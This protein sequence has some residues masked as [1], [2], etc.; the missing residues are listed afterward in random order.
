MFV[1]MSLTLAT[2]FAMAARRSASASVDQLWAEALWASLPAVGASTDEAAKKFLAAIA[3]T[4]RKAPIL[5]SFGDQ[6]SGALHWKEEFDLVLARIRFDGFDERLLASLDAR[7]RTPT[8]IRCYVAAVADDPNYLP[9]WYRLAVHAEG[10][11]Q[12]RAIAELQR[13]DPQNA[14]GWYLQALRESKAGHPAESLAA[15]EAGNSLPECRWYPASFPER[16]TL[17]VPDT[18]DAREAGIAG[19]RID[20]VM[21]R[22]FISGSEGLFSWAN[23]LTQL[24]SPIARQLFDEARAMAER[25]DR[26]GA[27]RRFEAVHKLGLKLLQIMPCDSMQVLIGKF[28]ARWPIEELLAAYRATGDETRSAELHEY[29]A[30]LARFHELIQGAFDPPEI[31]E[32]E[33]IKVLMTRDLAAEER[34]RVEAALR[35]SGLAFRKAN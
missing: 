29:G 32:T 31:A 3:R 20:A 15:L 12:D 7:E 9:A 35:K 21:L 23:P 4:N 11:L 5:V 18:K 1:V 28:L 2:L 25:G 14:M 33:K 27:I 8:S 19:L 10:D 13:R 30:R 17:I 16:C 6:A 22:K 26:D 34:E 24:R